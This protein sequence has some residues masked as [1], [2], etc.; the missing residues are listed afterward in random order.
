[1][2]LA[3]QP[4]SWNR[5]IYHHR[6]A[7]CLW[8]ELTTRSDNPLISAGGYTPAKS[9]FLVATYHP[10]RLYI[11]EKVEGFAML[12]R[13]IDLSCSQRKPYSEARALLDQQSI[14]AL[15]ITWKV[16][17]RLTAERDAVRN[18]IFH[19]HKPRPTPGIWSHHAGAFHLTRGCFSDSG[20]FSGLK[21]KHKISNSFGSPVRQKTLGFAQK[22]GAAEIWRQSD[23]HPLEL[24]Y[25]MI[26]TVQDYTCFFTMT[27]IHQYSQTNF[28]MLC[29]IP[30]LLAG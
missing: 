26:R 10:L 22:V 21:L 30:T 11:E 28:G 29:K 3:Y 23:D 27:F 20:W 19:R 13:L 4:I 5:F 18:R 16:L 24:K 15:L 14:L 8:L 9:P 7:I 2:F 25:Q 12:R 1:M 17:I 6:P